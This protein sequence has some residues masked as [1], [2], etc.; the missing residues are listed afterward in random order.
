M[1]T[2]GTRN[3][4]VRSKCVERVVGTDGDVDW[5][6]EE[7]SGDWTFDCAL[8]ELELFDEGV[9]EA[10]SERSHLLILQNPSSELSRINQPT[11]EYD[12]RA[13]NEGRC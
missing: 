13:C 7:V 11:V 6:L 4:S 3:P 1:R 10:S 8:E 2:F 9:W 12:Q 5:S